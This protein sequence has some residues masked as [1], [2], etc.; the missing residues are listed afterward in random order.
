MRPHSKRRLMIVAMT[1][2]VLGVMTIGS[3]AQAVITVWEDQFDSINPNWI[4]PAGFTMTSQANGVAEDGFEAKV[5]NTTGAVDYNILN[6]APS[7]FIQ[8]GDTLEFAV[9]TFFPTDT[10]GDYLELVALDNTSAAVSPFAT[11]DSGNSFTVIQLPITKEVRGSQNLWLGNNGSSG[12]GNDSTFYI[13]YIKVLRDD[14]VFAPN[15]V[16]FDDFQRAENASL[17]ITSFGGFQWM[18][19][20]GNPVQINGQASISLVNWTDQ[21]Q[22]AAGVPSIA[23]AQINSRGSGT[24]PTAVIDVNLADV[25]VT[26]NLRSSRNIA[27]DNFL[28]GIRYRLQQVPSPGHASDIQGYTVELTQ[29]EWDATQ[30]ASTVTLRW[31]NNEVLAVASTP[32]TLLSD[33]T[34]YELRVEA[35]GDN[36][37]VFIDGQLVIDFTETVAGR[38]VAGGAGFGGWFA[39][40][41]VDDFMVEDLSTALLTGDA[42][43]DGFVKADDLISVQTNFGAVGAVPLQGDANNDGFVKA[44]DLISVQTNFGAVAGPLA[45]PEPATLALLG[46]G[47]L[48]MWRRAS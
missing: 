44:D 2:G 45:V 3:S 42:N 38:D 18:E 9:R 19:T 13:D 28:G 14:P 10:A 26:A 30:L 25:A 32:A 12:A 29:G 20:E 16:A 37:K 43:K 23:A 40:W 47:V 27:S 17:G 6:A 15:V 7:Y 5:T 46:L 35:V 48:A 22:V 11:H 34:D 4:I 8:P 21:E 36:H 41:L 31:A 33:G 24:D 1:L 39:N